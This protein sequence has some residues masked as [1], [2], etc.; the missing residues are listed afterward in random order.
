[1]A[2]YIWP[3]IGRNCPEDFTEHATRLKADFDSVSNAANASFSNTTLL[4]AGL[5]A[6]ISMGIEKGITEA[7]S[8]GYCPKWSE[9]DKSIFRKVLLKNISTEAALEARDR[10]PLPQFHALHDSYNALHAK[11]ALQMPP[12][13]T[14]QFAGA[15]AATEATSVVDLV[16]AANKRITETN[17]V[18]S[19]ME[20]ATVRE[21]E[22]AKD[23]SGA[24]SGNDTCGEEVSEMDEYEDARDGQEVLEREDSESGDDS[25][26]EG[27]GDDDSGSAEGSEESSG[28]DNDIAIEEEKSPVVVEEKSVPNTIRHG[29]GYLFTVDL[30]IKQQASVNRLEGL[31]AVELSECVSSSLKKVLRGQQLSS[32]STRISSVNLLDNGN[33]RVYVH[34]ETREALQQVISARWNQDFDRNLIDPP[35]KTYTV[36]MHSVEIN[37]LKFRNRKEK[38]TIIRQLGD[39]NRAVDQVNGVNPIIGDIRWS[40]YTLPQMAAALIIDF[41][42]P[43]QAT[44]VLAHGLHWQGRRHGCERVEEGYRLLR[45]TKCQ[46]YGHRFPT[47]SAQYRCGKCSGQHRTTACGSDKVKCASCGG[48]H[49]AGKVKCPAKVEA[50]RGLGFVKEVTSQATASVAG[51]QAISSQPVRHSISAARTQTKISMPS[52]VSLDDHSAEREIKSEREQSLPEADPAQDTHPDTATL[53]KRFDDNQKE[54]EDLKKLVLALQTNSSSRTKRRA[55]EAF[56]GGAENE[57]SDMTAK[58]VKQE[59]STRENSMGLYRQPSP[60]IVNRPQ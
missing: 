60:F 48:G 18:Q 2:S 4:P 32:R 37:S 36:R 40:Q 44:Q 11:C 46:S 31:T 24:E 55:G 35:V 52:P 33:L 41:L 34:A 3:S 14:H 50:R 59:E 38:S 58:R 7:R 6:R 25:S 29:S 22:K 47:C 42:D 15:V 5:E 27:S 19:S 23:V 57:F 20:R 28:T 9:I 16:N 26:Q 17:R 43:E 13:M 39:A 54:V 56:A 1:M 51:A 21:E 8:N 12:A 53:L 10:I 30:E 45:C 49:R